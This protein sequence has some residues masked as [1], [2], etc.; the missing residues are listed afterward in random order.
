MLLI[1]EMQIKT[2]LRYSSHFSDWLT[3][4]TKKTSNAAGDAEKSGH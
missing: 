1:R 4:Q 2:T 3:S